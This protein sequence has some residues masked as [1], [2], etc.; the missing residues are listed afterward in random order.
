MAW[1]LLKVVVVM[2]LKHFKVSEFRGFWLHL[3]VGLL[4][5][6]DKLRGLIDVPITISP[7]EG[8]ILRVGE[9]TSQHFYGR[10][11]DVLIPASVDPAFIFSKAKEA[12]FSGVGYYPETASASRGY[13][14]WH[15]DVRPGVGSDN[16]ATWGELAGKT[17][18]LSDA[19][20]AYPGVA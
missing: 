20:S 7:A 12:G 17:V 5:S 9:G 16:P 10:A 13:R 8:A 6:L 4:L 1:V 2:K 18:S 14:R 15:F 3:S 11:I 19:M